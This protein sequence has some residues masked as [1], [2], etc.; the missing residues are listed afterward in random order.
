MSCD[1]IA[2]RRYS[3]LLTDEI[4]T[5]KGPQGRAW[6]VVSSRQQRHTCV[7]AGNGEEDKSA[8]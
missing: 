1:S 5:E 3:P 6:A 7:P 4:Q 8:G 2:G